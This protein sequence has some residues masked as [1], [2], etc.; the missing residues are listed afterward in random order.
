M[1]QVANVS[2]KSAAVMETVLAEGDLSRLSPEQR[3]RFYLDTCQSV[4]LNPYTRPF[5]YIRLNG[6]MVLYAKRDCADQLRKLHGVNVDIVSKGIEDDLY[7]VE[8]RAVDKTGRHDTDVGAVVI[9][10]LKGEARANAILKALTKAKR[11]VTLSICG[12]GL[13]DETEIGSIPDASPV[14]DAMPELRQ[15]T[16]GEVLD[17]RIPFLDDQPVYAMVRKEGT[18]T[19]AGAAEWVAEWR[20]AVDAYVKADA[21]ERLRKLWEANASAVD[22]IEAHDPAAAREVTAMVATALSS[23]EAGV[24]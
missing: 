13:L 21:I 11:R 10:G 22:V 9:G 12:L 1:N 18:R 5:D 6:K 2:N 17:D 24:A 14:V 4:G 19:F 3:L 16:T 23:A 20:K 15:P 7:V 8:V